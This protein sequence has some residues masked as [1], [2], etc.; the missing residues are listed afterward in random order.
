MKT[1][2]KSLDDFRASRR[3]ASDKRTVPGWEAFPERPVF[4]YGNEL[5]IDIGDDGRF[6]LLIG[7]REWSSWELGDLEPILYGY[8]WC[9]GYFPAPKDTASIPL[10]QALFALASE[11]EPGAADT[12]TRA[13]RIV[14]NM[15]SA[16]RT[17]E[18]RLAKA[19]MPT[20]SDLQ[21]VSSALTEASGGAP[22]AREAEPAPA[23]GR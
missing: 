19:E 21:Q 2:I 3:M 5:C 15:T 22:L 11:S 16:L 23:D 18:A 12:L 14:R 13:G 8:G 4:V 6:H 9:E 20:W 7:H 17:V 10:D 1:D